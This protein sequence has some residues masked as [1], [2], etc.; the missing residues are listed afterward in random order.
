MISLYQ[1]IKD[2]SFTVGGTTSNKLL[3]FDVDDTLE[4]IFKDRDEDRVLASISYH[5]VYGS[6]K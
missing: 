2:K 5:A 4:V 3:I 1:Y 6:S